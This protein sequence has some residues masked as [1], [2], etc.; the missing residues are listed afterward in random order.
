MSFGEEDKN[1]KNASCDLIQKEGISHI[2]KE[3]I[4]NGRLTKA[5]SGISQ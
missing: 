3:K 5:I 4:Q 1:T 2:I